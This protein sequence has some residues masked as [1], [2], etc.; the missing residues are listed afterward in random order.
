M[1]LGGV[2]STEAG[3][4]VDSDKHADMS[5]LVRRRAMEDVYTDAGAGSR[6]EQCFLICTWQRCNDSDTGGRTV[7]W[8]W[9]P[10]EV[11]LG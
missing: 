11:G 2:K 1:V 5:S 8:S 6:M 3:E 7:N 9:V 4:M 10:L